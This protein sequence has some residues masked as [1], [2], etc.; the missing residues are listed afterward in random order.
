M[1]AEELLWLYFF[2]VLLII[3]E[4]IKGPLAG[5]CFFAGGVVWLLA[6]VALPTYPG[7]SAWDTGIR[8]VIFL[9]GPVWFSLGAGLSAKEAGRRARVL[10]W[11]NL[12]G[13]AVSVG[14]IILYLSGVPRVFYLRY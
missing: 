5:R 10:R 14:L 12:V 4:M 13:F 2:V 1:S 8:L 11:L 6:W 7:H 3:P 9:V